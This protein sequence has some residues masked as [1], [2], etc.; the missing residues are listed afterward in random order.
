MKLQREAKLVLSDSGTISEESSILGF[1][2]VTL[3]DFIERPESLDT[4]SIITAGLEPAS[5]LAAVELVL[6]LPRPEAPVDYRVTD[7]SARVVTFIVG[8][9]HSHARRLGLLK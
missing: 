3:R 6:A 9:V 1:P 4:G 5:V 2:A 8:T 7:T